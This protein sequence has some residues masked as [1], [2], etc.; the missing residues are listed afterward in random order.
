M[1][2]ATST[3]TAYERLLDLVR[4]GSLLGSTA[5]LL[6]WDQETMMPSGGIEFRSRQLAQ[7]A[8]M[9]HDLQTDVRISDLLEESESE[10]A[11]ETSQQAANLREI[12]RDYEQAT[13]LPTDLVEE[14]AQYT[15]IA[16]HEWIHARE[17]SDF[18][19]FQ[20]YLERIVE[21]SRR[22]AECL[23]VPEGGEHWDALADTYEPGMRASEVATV[24]A[25]MRERLSA[26]ISDLMSAPRKPSNAL[27][28][29]VIPIE[30]QEA[31]VNRIAEVFGFDFTRGRLDRSVHP[32]CGGTHCN[33]V[34]MTTRFQENEFNDALGST[35]HETGHGLY[36]QGLPF[37]AIGLPLGDAVS[38]GVHESQ[39]RMW[40]NQVGRSEQFWQWCGPLAQE[41]L[42]APLADLSIEDFYGGANV[43]NPSYIRVEADEATYNLH[44][45]IRFELERAL[46][47]G[48]LEAADVPGA[49]NKL[50]KEYLDLDVPEDRLGCLQDVHWSMGAFGYFPTYTLGNLYCAQFFETVRA[51]IPGLM[52][53][54]AKGEFAPL[55][56]WLRENIH[57]HGRR[58]RAG[59]LCERVTG[60]PLSA[61]PL[62]NYLEGKL[63]PLYGA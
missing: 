21:L 3:T 10:C 59:E 47:G 5:S 19:H 38:L 49:W 33:D 42:G 60:K 54:F 4:Q 55:L 8:R 18:A 41:A 44:I 53:G 39:S 37:E 1:S 24:F 27:N 13:K 34:R 29:A 40:E 22:K 14:F 2:T 50:Y 7:L 62:M 28:E 23:G 51:E 32:F 63:R 25:P 9:C 20:P 57:Q 31:F 45:M 15:S 58:Y 48:D 12:R 52:D 26:L 17:K 46:M 30:K 6:G 61:E 11:D 35:M 16:Q 43:V 56:T 36:E